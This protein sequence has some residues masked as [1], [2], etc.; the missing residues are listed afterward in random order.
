MGLES[1]FE[2]FAERDWEAAEEGR[3][4]YAV[5]GCGWFAEEFALPS[6]DRGE[7]CEPSV[8]VSS[9]PEK[10]DRLATEYGARETLDYDAFQEGDAADA[11][12]AVY[13]CTPNATHLLHVRAATELG[14]DV[15]CEK[16]LE[17]DA[18]RT[19]RLIEACEDAGVTLMTA[20]RQQAEPAIRRLRPVAPRSRDGRRR[21]P[22]RPGD[23]PP[24]HPPL[25]DR[26]GP[27]FRVGGDEDF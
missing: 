25:S 3:V 19:E 14:K 16:P 4:R 18:G 1:Y 27:R 13:V 20:Y 11:Y 22:G 2:E 7:L 24:E 21:H 26:S 6:M 10:A 5:L 23:L 8:I 17:V 15:L 12:D 9:D